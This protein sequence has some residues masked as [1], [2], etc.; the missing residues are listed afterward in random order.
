MSA[1]SL[2]AGQPPQY[3]L[4][5]AA[6]AAGTVL[7][8]DGEGAA[9]YDAPGVVSTVGFTVSDAVGQV[10]TGTADVWTQ[11]IA[12]GGFWA[13]IAIRE[14]NLSGVTSGTI[15]HIAWDSPVPRPNNGYMTCNAAIDGPPGTIKV[16]TLIHNVAGGDSDIYWGAATTA[17]DNGLMGMSLSFYGTQTL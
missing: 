15:M 4:P 12:A 1:R 11:P 9:T 7:V 8:S 5:H 10:G 16:G 13:Q 17:G 2:C 14:S 6:G 3:T